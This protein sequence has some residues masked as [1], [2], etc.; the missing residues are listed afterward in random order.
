MEPRPAVRIDPHLL[1]TA[2]LRSVIEEL[3]TRDG[4]ELSQ[5]ESK[6]EQVQ[7]RLARGE[8]ELWFD[9]ETSTCNLV[10]V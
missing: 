3:V 7:S 8:L 2:T 5:L 6:V 1:A 9:P 4:T 10:A